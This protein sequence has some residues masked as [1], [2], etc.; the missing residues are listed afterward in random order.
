[1]Q[2]IDELSL[3]PA[4]RALKPAI[5]MG[6]LFGIVILVAGV[7]IWN[8]YRKEKDGKKSTS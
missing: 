7:S 4:F 1:M 6:I 5:Y 8:D 3:S 2:L